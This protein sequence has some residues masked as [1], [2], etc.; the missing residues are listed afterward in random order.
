MTADN[1]NGAPSMHSSTSEL[2]NILYGYLTRGVY[3]SKYDTNKK[4]SLWR[5]AVYYRV[6]NA[7]KSYIG[8]KA[9]T[10]SDQKCRRKETHFGKLPCESKMFC[11]YTAWTSEGSHLL[12]NKCY[13][14]WLLFSVLNKKVWL[15]RWYLTMSFLCRRLPWLGQNIRKDFLQDFTGREW[16]MTS[17]TI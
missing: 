9:V 12:F 7:E 1:T 2:H 15:C 4:R 3:T 14:A 10:K 17:K 16:A 6:D 8:A 13:M 11:I 5:K